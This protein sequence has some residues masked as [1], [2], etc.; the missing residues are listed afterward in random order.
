M[1][2]IR[3]F[4]DVT[5][6]MTA[7]FDLGMKAGMQL[8]VCNITHVALTLAFADCSTSTLNSLQNAMQ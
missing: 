5:K 7:Q 6:G 2:D 1:I 8:Q 3:I 4:T